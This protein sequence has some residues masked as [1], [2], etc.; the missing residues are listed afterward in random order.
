MPRHVEGRRVESA[1]ALERGGD[2]ALKLDPADNRVI[3]MWF[4]APGFEEDRGGNRIGG[5]ASEHDRTK[6]DIE[7]GEDGKV[8]VSPSILSRW[9]W[10]GQPRVFHAF[11]K[12]GTWEVL[13]DTV[14]ATFEGE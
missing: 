14:G 11:L 6:W 10:E 2:Y 13:D 7:V 12:A 9:L 8:T 3:C 5:P 4:I 1:E